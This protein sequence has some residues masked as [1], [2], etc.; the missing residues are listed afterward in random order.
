MAAAAGPVSLSPVAPTPI[1]MLGAFVKAAESFDKGWMLMRD[2]NGLLVVASAAATLLPGGFATKA[3]LDDDV[4]AASDTDLVN[5]ECGVYS[6]PML[7]TSAFVVGDKPAPIYAHNNREF[8]KSGAG[9]SIAGLFICLDDAR[10]T[11]HCIAWIGPEGAAMAAGIHSLVQ[12]ASRVARGVVYNNQ[13]DLAAFTVASDD[14]ITYVEGDR[15]LLVGQSTT[16]QNGI[17]TVGAVSAGAAALTRAADM[18]AAAKLPN[19]IVIEI[20]E[21]TYFAGS[22][23]KAMATQTGGWTVGTHDPAFYPRS[24]HYTVTLAAGVFTIGVGSTTTPDEPLF[25][26]STTKSDVQVTPNTPNTVTNTIDY[27]AAV[28]DRTAGKAGT[29]IV[30]AKAFKADATTNAA[31][32]SSVDVH[33]TNW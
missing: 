26:F 23:W 7:S 31:D 11:T 9:R 27:K 32:V 24:Q 5:V 16:T 22:S 6:V 10:P 14:G 13:A 18:P 12:A 4:P 15:V 30:I 2:A 19:G 20:S 29:A 21:G 33:V 28:G 3:M 17:Y 25:L 1:R 8:A